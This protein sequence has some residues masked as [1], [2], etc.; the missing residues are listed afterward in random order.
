MSVSLGWIP[1]YPD[2][3]DF[4]IEKLLAISE[5]DPEVDMGEPSEIG[6]KV[7][8]LDVRLLELSEMFRDLNLEGLLDCT[9][10]AK[11]TDLIQY[12]TPIEN[13]G[14]ANSCTAHAGVGIFEYFEKKAFNRHVDAS[15]LFLY[16]TTRNLLGFKSDVGATIRGTMGAM[17]LFGLPPERHWGY[18]ESMV[19]MEPSAFCYSYAKEFQALRYFKLDSSGIDAFELLKRIKCLLDASIPSMFGFTAFQSIESEKVQEDGMIPFP[20]DLDS[21]IGGHAVIAVGYDD[22][23]KIKRGRL[24]DGLED[25][26]ALIIRNSWGKQWGEGGYGYL[27]YEYVLRGIAK[28]FWSLLQREWVDTQQFGL[29]RG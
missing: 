3:R 26:G 22:E 13:Q 23:V 25:C 2:H 10:R 14:K 9:P 6:V 27:P 21:W 20:I 1:D 17:R 28:D 5:K 11:N 24:S 16:K 19:D 12:F 7:D 15:R 18:D 8:G 29:I 4:S